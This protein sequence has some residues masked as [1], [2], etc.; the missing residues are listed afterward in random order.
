[1]S[2]DNNF[3]ESLKKIPYLNKG[4]LEIRLK[5]IPGSQGQTLP[6]QFR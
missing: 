6:V 2:D 1:M 4:I 5:K 3:F